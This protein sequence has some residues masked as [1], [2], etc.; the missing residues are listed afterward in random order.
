MTPSTPEF[1]H[2]KAPENDAVC[3]RCNGRE[4][5]PR[6]VTLSPNGHVLGLAYPLACVACGLVRT[7]PTGGYP[8]LIRREVVS[9]EVVIGL[10]ERIDR[11]ARLA[12]QRSNQPDPIV[13]T[14]PAGGEG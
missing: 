1:D 13:R 2:T 10:R 8:E 5:Q 9:N 4:W 12:D 6:H 3:P 7:T 14:P 11:A